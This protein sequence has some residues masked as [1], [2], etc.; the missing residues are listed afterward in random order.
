MNRM[1]EGALIASLLLPPASLSA[2]AQSSSDSRAAIQGVVENRDGE[3]I[4]DVRVRAISRRTD[5]L[6]AETTTDPEGR[7]VLRPLPPGRYALV[8]YSPSYEQAVIKS[9][10]VK[11][12]QRKRLKRPVRLNP[13]KLYAVIDGAV[14]DPQGYLVPGARVVLERIAFQTEPVPKFKRETLTNRSGAFAFRVPAIRARYRLTAMAK[15]YAPQS[16]TVDV[17]G[18]ERRHVSIQF[19][20]KR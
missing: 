19:R 11:R 12:G 9:I 10:E 4:A 3:P 16:I 15:N 2:P 7:F 13:I 20:S 8:F 5:K 14:F 17:G 18:A 1:I 6:V